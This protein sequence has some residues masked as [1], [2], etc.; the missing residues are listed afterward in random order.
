L[1]HLFR[2]H[3]IEYQFLFRQLQLQSIC[4]KFILILSKGGTICLIVPPQTV[5]SVT[6]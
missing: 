6:D 1:G 5:L 2:S 4:Q 3:H